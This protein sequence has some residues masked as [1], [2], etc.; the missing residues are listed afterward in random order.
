MVR[1]RGPFFFAP[2]EPGHA[3]GPATSRCYLSGVRHLALVTALL[4]PAVAAPVPARA[5]WQVHRSDSSALLERAER[6]LLDRPDDED[7]ARRLVKLAGRDGRTKL[8]ER[9]RVRAERAAENGGKVAY[10]PVA[11]YAHLLQALGDAKAARAAFEQALRIAPQSVPALAGRARALADMGDDAGSLAAYDDALKVEHRVS[12]RRRLI[13]AALAVL[14]RGGDA[15][16]H[17]ADDKAVALLRDLA[18]AEPDSDEIAERLA[19]ALER[20]GKTAAAAEVLEARLRPGH[21]AAKLELAVRAARLRLAGRD[22]G[23]AARVAGSL[24]ALLRE[25]PPGDAERRRTVWALAFTV[26]RGRGT[27]PELARELERA[28]GPVEFARNRMQG[29]GIG[30]TYDKTRDVLS[31]LDRDK[32]TRVLDNNN[33]L[34]DHFLSKL[35]PVELVD[36]QT[37]LGH[38]AEAA[39]T[40]DRASARFAT[41]RGALQQLATIAA[42]CGEDRRA[43]K[44]WQRLHRLDPGN[45]IVIIGLGEAQFQAG[46]KIDAK[47]T[48]A[49]L[50]ERVRPPVHGHLR[51]TRGRGGDAR[52]GHRPGR[53]LDLLGPGRSGR[54]A[55]P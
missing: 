52:V 28:P 44:T 7:L 6:A 42:R 1:A 40:F 30:M 3:R 49:E 41:N 51:L 24:A 22:P 2:I 4:V 54:R 11:A 35:D 53:V 43:L 23:D 12:A 32:L 20:A 47:A 50:R 46:S 19:D 27:L 21:A 55:G 10:A 26:A 45:E 18:R 8:R 15:G 17:A 36:R 39:A 16:D 48:W 29:T 38:R 25:L 9:F 5:D 34:L 14:S 37:R 33:A 13:E 31:L